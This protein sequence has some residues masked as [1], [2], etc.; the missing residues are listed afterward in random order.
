MSK[1][2]SQLVNFVVPYVRVMTGTSAETALSI[3]QIGRYITAFM[4]EVHGL[5]DNITSRVLI[6]ELSD[7]EYELL[8]NERNTKT[9][10]FNI[11]FKNSE[12][13]LCYETWFNPLERL[14]CRPMIP[15]ISGDC[16]GFVVFIYQGLVRVAL[17]TYSKSFNQWSDRIGLRKS[18]NTRTAEPSTHYVY[19]EEAINSGLLWFSDELLGDNVLNH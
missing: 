15:V 16:P 4:R 14:T 19:K 6:R 2:L 1:K 12:G 13:M 11:D 3:N 5:P 7:Y 9:F 17:M 8:K 10:S 18:M